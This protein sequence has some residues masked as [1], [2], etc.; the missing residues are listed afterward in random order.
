M[1]GETLSDSVVYHAY[2]FVDGKITKMDI[3]QNVP[4][5]GASAVATSA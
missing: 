1:A 5:V 3:S 2:N 4:E